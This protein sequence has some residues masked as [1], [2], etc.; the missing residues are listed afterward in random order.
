MGV[1]ERG[2]RTCRFLGTTN[3][4]ERFLP[5][6]MLSPTA[7]GIPIPEH[8]K[9]ITEN[10]S[11][12]AVRLPNPLSVQ[13]RDLTKRLQRKYEPGISP[14]GAFWMMQ[15]PFEVVLRSQRGLPT[16]VWLETKVYHFT[17]L[18]I[19]DIDSEFDTSAPSCAYYKDDEEMPPHLTPPKTRR[20]LFRRRLT[21]ATILVGN[22]SSKVRAP[23]WTV[24]IMIRGQRKGVVQEE[25]SR[26]F[27]AA[28]VCVGAHSHT[29]KTSFPPPTRCMIV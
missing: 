13:A 19:F 23:R 9:Q 15:E 11:K 21:P 3:L 7:S 8:F 14:D 18:T 5:H 28:A 26:Y 10:P 17:D 16:E 1:S 4:V 24:D 20:S 27:A 25:V 29:L 2:E 12:F 22:A 6:N